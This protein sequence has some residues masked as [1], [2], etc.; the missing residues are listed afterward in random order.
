VRQPIFNADSEEVCGYALIYRESVGALNEDQPVSSE[1]AAKTIAH[2]F[3]SADA[4]LFT[5]GQPLFL[6]FTSQLIRENVSRLFKTDKLVIQIDDSASVN[7]T[8]LQDLYAL[9]KVG[10]RFVF[11]DFMFAQRYFNLLDLVDIISLDIETTPDTSLINITKVCLGMDK[12]LM[13]TN[14]NTHKD[15]ERA[16]DYGFSLIQGNYFAEPVVVDA[17][18]KLETNQ[19]NFLRLMSQLVQP[20]PNIDEIASII[21]SDVT[22]SY[23]LLKL[24]NSAYFSLRTRVGTIKQAV[25]IVGMRQLLDWVYLLSFSS[26]AGSS[27][28]VL[29]RLAF[30]RGEIAQSLARQVPILQAEHGDCYLVGMFSVLDQLLENNLS[31]IL[32]ELPLKDEVRTALLEKEG[33]MGLLYQLILMYEKGDWQEVTKLRNT[34]GLQE[35]RVNETYLDCVKNVSKTWSDLMKPGN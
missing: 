23:Q 16:K 34:L 6:T 4:A 10:Y 27:S 25:V 13:A 31:T 29:I 28:D 30:Q 33:P 12:K 3:S 7:T 26:G 22:M 24:V 8:L 19:I 15:F 21:S 14:V 20:E 9:R 11:N 17:G 5:E 1:D 2:I 35:D 18:K 32:A